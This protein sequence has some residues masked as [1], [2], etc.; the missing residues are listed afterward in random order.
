MNKYMLKNRICLLAAAFLLQSENSVHAADCPL[1]EG[2]KDIALEN[3]KDTFDYSF[4]KDV[5]GG[6]LSAYAD[7]DGDSRQDC[8]RFLYGARD[9]KETYAVF[10][11][12]FRDGAYK[13]EILL[14][15]RDMREI[16]SMGVEKAEP[17]EYW[18]ACGKGYWDCGSDETPKVVLK[19][20]GFEFFTFESAGSLIY[21]DE[22]NRKISQVWTSD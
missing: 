18:T 21:W 12:H 14:S 5:P 16:V 3:F 15:S 8:A 22:Q 17:G 7:I 11:S 1:P 20:Q 19:H 2:W 10:L 9:G 6:Y 13:H 4:R